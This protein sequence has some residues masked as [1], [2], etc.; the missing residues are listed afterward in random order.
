MGSNRGEIAVGGGQFWIYQGRVGELLTIRVN[1]DRPA[2]TD[3]DPL[4]RIERGLLDTYVI[5]RG[6][7]QSILAEDDDIEADNPEQTN[8]QIEIELP[9]DGV[10]EIEVRSYADKSGGPTRW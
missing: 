7:D 6:P 10:Y 5:L 4:T 9:S 2:G 3:T 8:S 1:A